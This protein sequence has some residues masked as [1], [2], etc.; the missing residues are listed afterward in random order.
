MPW[1]KHD[2]ILT[3]GIKIA[4]FSFVGDEVRHTSLKIMEASDID[5]LIKAIFK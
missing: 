4:Y 2:A 3:D 5:T 1:R